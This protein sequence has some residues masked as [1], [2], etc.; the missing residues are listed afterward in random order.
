ME[1]NRLGD[2]AEHYA[3]TWL[4]DQGFEVFRNSGCTGPVDLIAMDKDGTIILIDVKSGNYDESQVRVSSRGMTDQQKELGVVQ[5]FFNYTDRSLKF[6]DHKHET[7]YS[8]YRDK[9]HPQLDL[10]SCDTGC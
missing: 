10:V 1:R 2:L 3:I 6:V 8:R 5:V 7:T 9:Q 4:W